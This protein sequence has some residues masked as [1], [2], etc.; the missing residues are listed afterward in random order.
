M[1][2]HVDSNINCSICILKTLRD[3]Y[4]IVAEGRPGADLHETRED[5]QGLVR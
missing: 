2:Y 3:L 1:T 4:L 5:R